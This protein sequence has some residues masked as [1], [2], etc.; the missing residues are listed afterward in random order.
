M[1]WRAG[2]V[3]ASIRIKNFGLHLDNMRVIAQISHR[4]E[5]VHLDYTS[6]DALALDLCNKCHFHIMPLALDGRGRSP[7]CYLLPGQRY[8]TRYA[9]SVCGQFFIGAQVPKRLAFVQL[10]FAADC[11][12]Q[13]WQHFGFAWKQSM[14]LRKIK[15]HLFAICKVL[16]SHVQPLL[17]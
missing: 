15:K 3:F 14:G 17:R 6:A 13:N 10:Q 16:V 2:N 11:I 5:R 1:Q 4:V 12:E 7:A 8:V 9:G